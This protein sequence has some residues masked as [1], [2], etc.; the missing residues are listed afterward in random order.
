MQ[1][2]QKVEP[3]ST[4]CGRFKPKKLCETSC[5]RACYSLQPTCNL[6]A[7]L[8]QYYLQR[9]LHHVTLALEL[10]TSLLFRNDCRDILKSLQAAARD[11]NPFL[12]HCTL[13]PDMRTC[14][15]SPAFYYV[16]ITIYLLCFR[17]DLIIWEN[18]GQAL[19]SSTDWLF[20][21]LFVYFIDCS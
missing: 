19:S 16:I 5:Q 3:S 15:M 8:F 7:T 2:L 17:L 20:F 6:S 21:R 10:G 12:K 1:S 18:F 13:Q 9:N 14:N 11:C 4:M